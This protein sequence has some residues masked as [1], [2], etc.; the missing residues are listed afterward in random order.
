MEAFASIV[1]PVFNRKE[2]LKRSIISC[3]KQTYQKIEILVVDD[4]SDENLNDIITQFGDS[5]IKYYRLSEK[6]NANV[7]RNKGIEL[8]TGEFI[9]FLDSDDEYLSNHIERYINHFKIT[10]EVDGLF[11]AIK[12][13]T[14]Q[15]ER[16]SQPKKRKNNQSLINYI[17]EGNIVSTPT[18]AIRKHCFALVKFD[19][20]LARHQEWDFTQRFTEHYDLQMLKG[21]SVIVNWPEKNTRVVNLEATKR[22]MSKHRAKISG[23]NYIKYNR[24]MYLSAVRGNKEP[25][26]KQ[27]F[28]MEA[29]SKFQ[30]ITRAEYFTIHTVGQSVLK[31]VFYAL[32]Y[33]LF[34]M[35]LIKN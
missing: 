15:S 33:Y 30:L 21:L 6:G 2:E 20:S 1:I 14:G 16:V 5:R 11:S 13:K 12:I 9:F 19:P 29:L 32:R 22:F 18:L 35:Q 27:Y 8:S 28:L 17:L 26:V 7:A 25:H 31:K 4:H 3:L 24:N 34:K 23:L 10:P